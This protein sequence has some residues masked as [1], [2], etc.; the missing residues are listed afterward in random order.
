METMET[1][2]RIV[3]ATFVGH[4]AN[5]GLVL[6]LPLLFPFI[7]R[8]FNLS[9][10]QIG[11]LGG[12]LVLAMGV[13]QVFTGYISD[14][15]KVK[16]PFIALGLII[17]AVSLFVMSFCTT[18][19]CL[20]IFNLLAGI[21]ASFYHPCGI[22]LLVKP[23]KSKIQGRVLGIHAVGGCA[24]I[25]VYPALAGV[26]LQSQGWRQVLLMLPLTGIIAASLFFFTEENPLS[27]KEREKFTLPY[28][29][30][31][32]LILLYGCIAMFFRGFVTFLPI[33]LGEVGYQAATI[34]IVVTVF[35]GIGII[36]E[37]MGGY[38]SDIYS[39]KKIMFI[40]FLFASILVVLLFRSVWAFILP[41]GL[42]T[43][44]VWVP[45]T[46]MYVEGVPEAWYGTALG[47]LQGIAGLMAFVSPMAMGVI[48]E[49]GGIMYSF[50]FLSGV[51]F[52]GAIFSLKL[53]AD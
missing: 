1:P 42:V 44:T 7:A 29:K 9:Y 11:L 37:Y 23:M 13:G 10:T 14:F 34:A 45:A 48:A 8:D 4:F 12:S 27:Y 6:M 35:Y 41:L 51:A 22:A 49:T 50:W 47:L 3:F 52:C 17:L 38:L 39:R 43:Y 5:D 28:K 2:H 21:G 15:S 31:I 24:G 36:G 30:S 18:F 25:L 20:I 26:I 53:A 32:V 33:R 16:W 19:A 40:S 46:A